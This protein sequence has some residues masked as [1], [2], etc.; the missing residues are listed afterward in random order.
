MGPNTVGWIIRKKKKQQAG[1]IYTFLSTFSHVTPCLALSRKHTVLC[2]PTGR[3][4]FIFSLLSFRFFYSY[5]P[6]PKG[7]HGIIFTLA[8]QWAVLPVP[9]LREY[10]FLSACPLVFFDEHDILAIVFGDCR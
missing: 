2:P 1:T 8:K 7:L 9:S 5:F 6:A 4:S 3:H 10:F